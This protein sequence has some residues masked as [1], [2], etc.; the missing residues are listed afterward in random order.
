MNAF[1]AEALIGMVL[2][3]GSGVLV[4]APIWWTVRNGA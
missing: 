4:F 1:L 2:V 3:M